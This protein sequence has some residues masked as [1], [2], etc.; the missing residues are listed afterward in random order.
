MAG[1]SEAELAIQQ[2]AYAIGT[3]MRDLLAS[4]YARNGA[5]V[6]VD[7]ESKDGLT[8]IKIELTDLTDSS[9]FTFVRVSLSFG[10]KKE[11]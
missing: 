5:K 4:L 1:N 8:A 2:T 6:S 3:A 10:H 11:E 7:G 9:P